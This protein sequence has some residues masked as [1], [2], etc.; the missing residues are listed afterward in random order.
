MGYRLALPAPR[1]ARL[2]EFRVLVLDRHP[3]AE[4]DAEIRAALHR[5]G[6][7]LEGLGAA[8]ARGSHLLPDLASAHR[9]YLAMLTTI[10][11]L[12]GPPGRDSTTAHEWIGLLGRQLAV[13]NR[14]RDL[15]EA[16][17]VVL[18]PTFGTVAFPHDDRDMDR[19][20]LTIDG[21]E[22]PYGAQ[23]AWS[24]MASLANLPATA[25]PI[26]RTAAGLPIGVQAMGPYLEDRTTI[27][28]A[29]LVE[30]EFG[31]VRHPA[32]GCP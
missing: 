24:G 4:L 7:E 8:V 14:W 17:D 26:G 10:T 22:T 5:L 1:R 18:A 28:F 13:R 27:A 3:T 6:D 19:R 31:G 15:F 21:R 20:T 23:M 11:T 16:F 2:S 12:G 32:G 29:A 30:R 9:C 25:L